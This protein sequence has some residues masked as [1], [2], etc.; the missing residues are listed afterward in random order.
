MRVMR[1]MAGA[2]ALLALLAPAA[3]A[4]TAPKQR[5][6]LIADSVA[7]AIVFDLRALATVS[8]GVDLCLE[9]GPAR[10]LA[11]NPAEGIAPPTVLE[12][13]ALLGKKLGPTVIV[14]V[15]DNDISALYQQHMEA[16]LQALRAAGVKHVVWTTLHE[17]AA[18]VGFATMNAAIAAE[19][20]QHPELSVLDWNAAANAHPE[21]LQDD[22][23]HLNGEGPRAF[24]RLLHERLVSLGVAR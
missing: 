17:S 4:K 9:A 13:V 18:H 21:W 2:L 1:H 16:V 8:R 11:E 12:L 6:T 15:G 14:S 5:V 3:A 22:R 24:A 10:R 19:A 23:V 7:G 20:V